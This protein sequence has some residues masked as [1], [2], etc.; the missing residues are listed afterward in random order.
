MLT[1]D[2][3]VLKIF[4]DD[5]RTRHCC[6]ATD[7]LRARAEVRRLGWK[8]FVAYLPSGVERTD[9]C[10]DCAMPAPR[11]MGAWKGPTDGIA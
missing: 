5:C 6:A 4:C 10:P 8:S 11:E 9:F 3:L 2:G 7:T 1:R